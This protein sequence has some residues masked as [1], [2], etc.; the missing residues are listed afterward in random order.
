[1]EA[2]DLLLITLRTAVRVAL[3]NMGNPVEADHVVYSFIS[4]GA[5]VCS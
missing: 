4:D 3:R 1:M 5:P 2:E